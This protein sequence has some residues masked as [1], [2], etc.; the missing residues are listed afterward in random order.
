MVCATIKSIRSEFA[1]VVETE[2]SV[3]SLVASSLY[4]YKQ[5]PR[6]PVYVNGC[7]HGGV[8]DSL[9]LAYLHS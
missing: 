9:W 4:Y 7:G 1:S 3:E 5:S 2:R 6:R 8:V